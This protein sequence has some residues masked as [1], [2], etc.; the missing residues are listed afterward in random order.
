MSFRQFTSLTN[1]HSKKIQNHNDS[2]EIYRMFYNLV[3]IH[4]CLRVTPAIET[5]VAQRVCPLGE[6]IELMN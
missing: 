5:V 3:R 4:S 1:A 6:M 2:I